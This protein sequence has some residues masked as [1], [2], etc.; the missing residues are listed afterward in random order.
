MHCT[1]TTISTCLSVSDGSNIAAGGLD[2]C[3]DG[4]PQVTHITMIKTSCFTL[5]SNITG[6]SQICINV[7]HMTTIP[8]LVSF[9]VGFVCFSQTSEILVVLMTG[10]QIDLLMM[11]KKRSSLHRPVVA[12]IKATMNLE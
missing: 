12:V 2:N 4:K 9:Y 10:T 5:S 3:T 6:D 7:Q 11:S 8:H 1:L